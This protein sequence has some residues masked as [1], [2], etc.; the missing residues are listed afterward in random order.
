MRLRKN[1][2]NLL[3]NYMPKYYQNV[4]TNEFVAVEDGG[5]DSLFKG[6]LIDNTTNKKW[7][8]VSAVQAGV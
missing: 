4:E 1:H 8:E 2:L 3:N 7:R 5:D 6:D